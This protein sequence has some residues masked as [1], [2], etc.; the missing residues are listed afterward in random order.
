M[1]ILFLN[2][3]LNTL[4]TVIL[5]VYALLEYN[6]SKIGISE[7]FIKLIYPILW[8]CLTIPLYLYLLIELAIFFK[9][10]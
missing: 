3:L 6:Q 5:N 4:S 8:L 9:L 10:F 1:K 2:A 7:T